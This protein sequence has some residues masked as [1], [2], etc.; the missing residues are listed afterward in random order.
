MIVQEENELPVMSRIS[1]C[2]AS[3]EQHWKRGDGVT[4][5]VL[6]SE[7]GFGTILYSARCSGA[8]WG[9]SGLGSCR[10]RRLLSPT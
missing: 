4:L 8:P 5:C 6:A 10:P 1:R 3:S 2:L 9:C 7:D